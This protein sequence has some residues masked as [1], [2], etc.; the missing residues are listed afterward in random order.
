M[1]KF[2]YILT[3]GFE[4]EAKNSDEAYDLF[5]KMTLNQAFWDNTNTG[6]VL[7]SGVEEYDE[8]EPE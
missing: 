4:V 2:E 1:A 5:Q 3:A 7:I 6:I 8:N